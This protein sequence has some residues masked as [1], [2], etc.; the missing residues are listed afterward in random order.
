MSIVTFEQ[1]GEQNQRSFYFEE[2][3]EVAWRKDK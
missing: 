2:K 1:G 3:E